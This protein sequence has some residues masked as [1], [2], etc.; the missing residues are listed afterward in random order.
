MNDDNT[1]PV[2]HTY[3]S[4]RLKL[5]YVD[6]GNEGAPPVLLVHGGRDHARSW[7]WVAQGLRD[8][9][10]VIAVDLRGHGDSQWNTCGTYN[11]DDFVCD[12]DKL[13]DVADLA[14]V[15]IIAHSMGSV[16]CQRH[17]GIFPDKVARLV[18]IEGFG[19]RPPLRGDAKAPLGE[20]Y[21]AWMEKM[22]EATETPPLRYGDMEAAVKRMA[23]ANSHLSPDQVRHLTQHGVNRNEDGS[24]SWKFDTGIYARFMQPTGMRPPDGPDLWK[25]VT[26]PT[27]LIRGGDSWGADPAETGDAD[28]FQNARVVSVDDAG[29]WVH[30]DQLDAFLALVRPFLAD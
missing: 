9:Y 23:E 30:H 29:H 1:G 19:G 7:D 22:R 17:A 28:H 15:R 27:L 16:I 5:H 8:D 6:W 25:L 24:Y 21:R 12:L 4:Q 13:V 14:P 10:R 20:R 2:S 3:I 11:T 26:C 18:A